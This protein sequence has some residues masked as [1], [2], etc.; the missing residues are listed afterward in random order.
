MSPFAPRRSA[1]IS[2]KI[3]DL[4]RKI[5]V[6]QKLA[7]EAFDRGMEAGIRAATIDISA[8]VKKLIDG[9]VLNRQSGRLWRS[10]QPEV[11]RRGGR[12]IGIVGTDV[13]YA[14]VHEF[15]ATI[16]PKKAGGLLFFNIDGST[17]VAKEVKIPRRPFMS[18][19]FDERKGVAGKLIERHV[20]RSVKNTLEAG[21]I[22]P[23]GKRRG[24]GFNANAN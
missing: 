16:R 21:R 8:R 2:V 1:S 4:D 12:I 17:V 23:V 14:A 7:P 6:W 24:V 15:G 20:M 9:P 19:A 13:K 10:I 22:V 3:P 18:R 5:K 11:F